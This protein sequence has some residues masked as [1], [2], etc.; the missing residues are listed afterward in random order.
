MVAGVYRYAL[1]Q[2]NEEIR[3][4]RSALT[5]A[6]QQLAALIH[7]LIV[8]RLA[9]RLSAADGRTVRPPPFLPFRS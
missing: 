6:G 5:E 9:S 4:F 1:V 8:H 3:G 7:H 2:E